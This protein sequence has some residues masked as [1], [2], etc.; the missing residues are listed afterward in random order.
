MEAKKP[1]IKVPAWL[2][3]SW[4]ADIHLLEVSSRGEGERESSASFPFPIRM[5]ILYSSPNPHDPAK[6]NSLPKALPPNNITFGV[7]ASIKKWRV[8]TNSQSIT[9]LK[10]CFYFTF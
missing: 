3:S 5:L 1:K 7:R 2:D 8:G 6:S 4:L 10:V 9:Y